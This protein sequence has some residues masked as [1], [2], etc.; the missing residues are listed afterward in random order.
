VK[1]I[2][3]NTLH[4]KNS[5]N[6]SVIR[7]AYKFFKQ[8]IQKQYRKFEKKKAAFQYKNSMKFPRHIIILKSMRIQNRKKIKKNL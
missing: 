8:I 3:N 2:S 7:A 6:N 5:N 1:N 4:Q